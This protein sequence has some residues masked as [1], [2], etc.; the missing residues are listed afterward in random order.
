V[1]TGRSFQEV[2]AKD[3][4]VA[5]RAP[6]RVN[7]MGDHTDYNQGLVLP[8]VIPQQTAVEVAIGSGLHEV[9]SATL[10]R[11]ARF[12]GGALTDFARYVGGCVR[13]LE[14]GGTRIP[15]LQLRIVS[16][17]PVGAGL[18]SSA[19]LEV[20][21]I[22]ALD[23]L[24]GLKLEAEEVASL[25]HKAE[26][27]YAGVACGIMDQMASSLAEP[28]L[29][30]FLDTMTMERRLT[31]LPEGTELLVINSEMPRALAATGYNQR[32]AEC[33]AAAAMLGVP[34]LRLVEDST[35]LERLP[36][37]LK[38]RA[39]HVVSENARVLAA[40]D[41]DAVEFGRLMI[42]SHA[43]LRDDYAVSLPPIDKLV[44]ALENEQGVFGARLTGAGFGGCCVALVAAGQAPA[45][46]REIVAR[47]YSGC[48]PTVVIP[49]VRPAVSARPPAEP[50]PSR[51]RL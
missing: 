38:E 45:I 1:T 33:E 8:T 11:T 24:L 48:V 40:L 3:P 36:S 25:A 16:D 14:E 4:M 46:G 20:A 19:A 23:A 29:M 26:V 41:A 35:A 28:D 9:Y 2:F 34:N 7:L 21:T 13:V 51:R 44:S 22:R 6:G 31:H 49:D 37:P 30:L 27:E 43:S 5:A 10:G 50:I 18:S 47:A 15:P 39:R 12:G 17:V 42:A 32:R